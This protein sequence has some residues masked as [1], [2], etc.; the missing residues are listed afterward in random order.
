MTSTQWHS[1]AAFETVIVHHRQARC[2]ARAKSPRRPRI[3]L[4]RVRM[5][6]T[7]HGLAPP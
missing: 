5:R 4:Y 1:K 7:V 2:P 3:D 6:C